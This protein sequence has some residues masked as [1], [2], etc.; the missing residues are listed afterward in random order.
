[1][2]KYHVGIDLHKTVAQI[3]VVDAQGEI[4]V[5]SRHGL[6]GPAEGQ[7][8]VEHLAQWRSGRFAVEA[9]GSN[10]WFVNA[11]RERGLEVFVVH[12]AALGLKRMNSKKKGQVA[13]ARKMAECVWRLLNDPDNFDA[14]RPFG[15]VPLRVLQRG[16]ST[17]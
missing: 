14:R 6:A 2:T 17:A 12:A 8:F 9:I 3:C 10:R 13:G 4:V 16:L 11:C 7:L 5:E 15:R 1:M